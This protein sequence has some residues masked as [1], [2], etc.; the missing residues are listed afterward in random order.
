[1]CAKLLALPKVES[2]NYRTQGYKERNVLPLESRP[3]NAALTTFS[4]RHRICG[5]V[6]YIEV[7]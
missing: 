7:E 1:M 2:L 4:N 6:E 5:G 3:S